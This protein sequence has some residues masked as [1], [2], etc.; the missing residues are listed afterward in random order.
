MWSEIIN[1][2]KKNNV[3]GEI[4]SMS[5]LSKEIVSVTSIDE[6]YD[7][8]RLMTVDVPLDRANIISFAK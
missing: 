1:I 5:Y 6:R 4:K 7:I 2:V 3:N 8:C